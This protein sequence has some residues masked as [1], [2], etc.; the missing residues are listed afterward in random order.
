MK[1]SRAMAVCLALL[2]SLGVLPAQARQ[3]TDEMGRRVEVPAEPKRFIGLTP[4]LT[5]VLFALG[6]GKRVVGG[7]TWADYPPAARDLPRVGPYV[8]PNLERILSLKPDLVLA[9][10]EGN[11]PWVVER[12]SALG[13][14]VYVTVPVVPKDLPRSLE[15]LGDL[16]GASQAGRRLAGQLKIEMAEVDQRLRGAKPRP[17]LLVIGS[18]PLVSVGRPTMNHRLLT[19]AGG[20]NIAEGINQRWPRLNLEYIIEAKPQVI[21]LS[22]MERGQNLERDLAYWRA[23][24]GVGDRPGVRVEWVSSDL[25]DR[26]GPRLGQGLKDLAKL[27]HPERFAK[28][29]SRP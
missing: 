8:S 25:I 26:P 18:R 12:L 19:M 2:L 1:L 13:V 14:P 6:L 3:V 4:S 22:T 16:L 27:I 7:T 10:K 24:P 23:L 9:N 15:R 29:A 20:R 11:P 21:I 28:E 5:E 17:T